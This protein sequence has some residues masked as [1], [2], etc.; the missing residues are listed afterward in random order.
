[1]DVEWRIRERCKMLTQQVAGFHIALALRCKADI[2]AGFI[3]EAFDELELPHIS[4]ARSIMWEG[5][6]R[7]EY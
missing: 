1:M 5:I 3:E 7:C 4:R 2:A 6:S